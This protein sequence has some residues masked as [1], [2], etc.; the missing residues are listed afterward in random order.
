MLTD[1]AKSYYRARESYYRAIARTA[2]DE[3]TRRTHSLLA[4][5]QARQFQA[6]TGFT[7]MGSV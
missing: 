4:D 3:A 2:T 1:T 6:L 5:C 7:G